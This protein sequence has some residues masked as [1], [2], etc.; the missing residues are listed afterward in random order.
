MS[1]NDR[2]PLLPYSKLKKQT[3]NMA[4]LKNRKEMEQNAKW[5]A[6]TSKN[7]NRETFFIF[8]TVYFL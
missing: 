2:L 3:K 8:Q 6:Q 4:K 5:E 7:D 1:D